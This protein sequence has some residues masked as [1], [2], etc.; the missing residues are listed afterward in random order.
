[1]DKLILDPAAMDATSV[2]KIMAGSIVP[3]PIG[4]LSTVS[5]DGV[6]N[7]APFSF[8]NMVSHIPP[9]VSVSIT[10]LMPSGRNKDTL[11]NILEI[12]EFVANIVDEKLA[13]AVDVCAR[14]YPPEVDE[15]VVAGVTPAPSTLVRPPRVEESMINFECEVAHIFPLPESV[16]TLVVGRVRLMH[17]HPDVMGNNG[18]IDIKRLAPIG[19]LV[20][21]AYCRTADSFTLDHDTFEHL[22]EAGHSSGA[23]EKRSS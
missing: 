8:F 12:G 6:R 17:V 21:N 11:A 22:T 20:G 16:N 23:A 18:R 19:R 14:E 15:F 1:V 10:Q 9:L 2:Y 7:L 13:R 4:F 3:R 5:R